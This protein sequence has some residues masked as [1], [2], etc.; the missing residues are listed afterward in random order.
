MGLGLTACGDD[1]IL[2]QDV[3]YTAT[4]QP[5]NGYPVTGFANFVEGQEADAFSVEVDAGGLAEGALHPQ[6]VHATDA[7][8]TEAADANDDGF[9]D[10]VEGLP[11][12]GAILIPLDGDLS[13]QEAGMPEGYPTA[14]AAGRIEYTMVTQLSAM[15]DDLRSADPEQPLTGLEGDL[16]LS[17][18]SVVLHGIAETSSTTLPDTMQSIGETPA[19]VTVPVACATI[20]FSGI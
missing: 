3:A 14:D 11:A 8:P 4:L 9:V 17:T 7:C 5:L 10:V 18:R 13:D 6:H 1:E 16:S 19:Y 15:V 12:Y 20:E 2:R